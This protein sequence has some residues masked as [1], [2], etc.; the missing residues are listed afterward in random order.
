MTNDYMVEEILSLAGLF[1]AYPDGKI[2]IQYGTDVMTFV[3]WFISEAHNAFY[4][5]AGMTLPEALT[6]LASAEGRN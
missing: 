5:A 1:E 6:N 2:T 4:S 3:V